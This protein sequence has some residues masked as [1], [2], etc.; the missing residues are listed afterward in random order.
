MQ[1]NSDYLFVGSKF[2]KSIDDNRYTKRIE[3]AI[4][5]AVMNKKNF[6]T[7][8]FKKYLNEQISD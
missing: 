8:H 6:T 3:R 2:P 1:L 4:Y 5:K 7:S